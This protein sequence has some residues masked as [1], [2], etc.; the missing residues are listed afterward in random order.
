MSE[1]EYNIEPLSEATQDG[2]E[3]IEDLDRDWLADVDQALRNEDSQSTMSLI[4]GHTPADIANL[5][6]NLPLRRA[7]S[8]FAL[9]PVGLQH[10][11]RTGPGSEYPADHKRFTVKQRAHWQC[12]HVPA[13]R[14]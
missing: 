4:E 10:P 1:N 14:Q 7:R 5:L 11:G 8:L 6:I 12:L 9:L 3:L 13:H 2:A